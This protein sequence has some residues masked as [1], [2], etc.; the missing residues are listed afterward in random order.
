MK[1]VCGIYRITSPSGK[2][3]IGQ[4]NNIFLRWRSYYNPRGN[5]QP[6][7]FSSI[8]KYGWAAH[9]KE[10]FPCEESALN[11]QEKHYINLFQTFN[12][13]HGMN[14]RAGG[15]SGGGLSDETKEKIRNKRKFQVITED[16]R[17]STSIA[18][19]GK[20]NSLGVK[21]GY[22]KNQKPFKSGA[23]HLMASLTLNTQ[24]GIFYPTIKEAASSVPMPSTRLVKYLLGYRRNRSPFIKA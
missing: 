22:R 4:S 2:I 21:H 9:S 8:R 20:Q 12:T 3:Y 1:I 19:I 6:K 24:T 17:A 5:K 18:M 16:Q 14:L 11:E 13:I 23:N 7:L 10:I 15:D